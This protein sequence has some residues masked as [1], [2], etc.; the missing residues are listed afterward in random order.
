MVDIED[1]KYAVV[2]V[3]RLESKGK[4]ILYAAFKKETV[5]AIFKVSDVKKVEKLYRTCEGMV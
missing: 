1:S 3:W 5:T 4:Q 2:P